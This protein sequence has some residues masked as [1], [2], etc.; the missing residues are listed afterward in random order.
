[1][2]KLYLYVVLVETSELV[3]I[4]IGHDYQTMGEYFQSRFPGCTHTFHMSDLCIKNSSCVIFHD[5][6]PGKNRRKTD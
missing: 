6:R 1:M 3:G 5:V 4:I 2:E